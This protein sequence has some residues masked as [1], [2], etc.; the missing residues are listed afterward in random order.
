MII[1][2]DETLGAMHLSDTCINAMMYDKVVWCICSLPRGL[3]TL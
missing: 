1:L 2:V 3:R